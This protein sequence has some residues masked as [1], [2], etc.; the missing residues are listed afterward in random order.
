M[1]IL[2][3]YWGGK[4]KEWE[5]P[6][7]LAVDLVCMFGSHKWNIFLI[8]RVSNGLAQFPGLLVMFLDKKKHTQI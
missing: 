3:T 4:G 5:I 1:L 6:P 2:T 8:Q 7:D